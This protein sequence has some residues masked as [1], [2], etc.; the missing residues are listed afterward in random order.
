MMAHESSIYEWKTVNKRN[1]SRKNK[2]VKPKTKI[3]VKL[4]NS[5]DSL[6]VR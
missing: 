4:N 3:T 5:F 2:A 6:T 1:V